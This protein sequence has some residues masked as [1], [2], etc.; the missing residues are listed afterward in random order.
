[1]F[2]QGVDKGI[3]TCSGGRVAPIQPFGSTIQNIVM[4]RSNHRD[5]PRPSFTFE[6]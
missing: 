5:V 4:L 2:R 3:T 1:M 6:P